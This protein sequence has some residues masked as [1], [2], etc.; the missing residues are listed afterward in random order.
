MTSEEKHQKWI[1]KRRRLSYN[2]VV[3]FFIKEQLILSEK[4]PLKAELWSPL[5]SSSHLQPSPQSAASHHP[6]Q[7]TLRC[8]PPDLVF[9]LP[10]LWKEIPRALIC[11]GSLF[12]SK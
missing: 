5:S 2:N 7:K 8:S 10:H 6:H 1:R 4:L 3:D 12:T 9:H 11:H